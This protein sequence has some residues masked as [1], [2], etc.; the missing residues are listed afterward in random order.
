[1]VCLLYRP[2]FQSNPPTTNKIAEG[3]HIISCLTV[4]PMPPAAWTPNRTMP[5][6]INMTAAI[7]SPTFLFTFGGDGALGIGGLGF[8]KTGSGD[9]TLAETGA[10]QCGHVAASVDKLLLHST[11]VMRGII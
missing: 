3:H 8:G 10:P 9:V 5:I 1:M 7:L 11:Q 2:A 6:K 4:E